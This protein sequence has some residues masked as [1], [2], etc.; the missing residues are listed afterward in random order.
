[1]ALNNFFKHILTDDEMASINEAVGLFGSD[2]K[3]ELEIGFKHID[4]TNYIRIIEEL[5]NINENKIES[6]VS[7]DVSILLA[8]GNSYRVS[9]QNQELIDSFLDKCI[10]TRTKLSISDIQRYLINMKLD[11]PG[12]EIMFKDKGS[13]TMIPISDLDIIFK[14]TKE[15][16]VKSDSSKP[17]LS[18]G[19]KILFRLKDRHSFVLNKFTRIDATEVQQSNNPWDLLS[20]RPHY[21]LE[22]EIINRKITL[23]E[24]FNETASML[25]I[26]QETSLPIGKKEAQ[27]VIAEYRKLLNSKNIHLEKRS[28]VSIEAHHIVRFIPNKYAITDKADGDRRFLFSVPDGVYLLS[29]NLTVTKINVTITKAKYQFMLLDGELVQNEHGKM[30]LLFDVVYANQIDYRHGSKFNLVNRI[31]VL[32]DIVS[33]CFGSLI[34]FKNFADTHTELDLNSISKFYAEELSTYWKEFRSQLKISAKKSELFITRK[35][36]FIPYGIES[37]EIFTYADLVWRL[38][39]YK[40]LVPYKLDGIIYTP[41]N[42]PYMIRASREEIDTVPLEYKWKNPEQNSIDFWIKFETDKNGSDI[43]FYDGST[44]N[45]TGRPYKIA[46]L[47]VGIS[48]GS[49][50]KPI[51]FK[52]GGVDQKAYIY[53]PG[54][55]ARDIEER[56]IDDRTVVEFIFDHKFVLDSSKTDNLI[57]QIDDAYKWIPI[58]TRYDKTE[59]VNKYNRMYGNP[60]YI[61]Q[62]IYR[63]IINPITESTISLLAKPVSFQKEFD[64]LSKEIKDDNQIPLMP[65][66]KQTFTYYEKETDH[67]KGMRAYHNWIKSN[68]ILTYCKNKSAVLDIGCGRGG[69]ISKFIGAGVGELV[70]IDRDNN[71]LYVINDCAYSRYKSA[72]KHNPKI[73]PMVFINAD[74]TGLFNVG[75]QEQILTNMSNQNK[76]LITTYLSKG[77]KYDVINCQFSLHYYLSDAISWK[78]FCQNINDHTTNNAYLLITTFDGS[79]VRSK[80]Q[81][82]SKLTISYTDNA[83]TKSTFA[84]ITKLYSDSD[85]NKLGLAIGVHNS[86]IS[87]SQTPPITEYIVEP[88]FLIKSMEKNCGMELVE[89]DSFFNLFELYKKYFGQK[90]PTS[91][92]GTGKKQY[93]IISM[94]YKTLDPYLKNSFTEAEI[95]IA[96]ASF[97]FSSLNRYYVFKKKISVDFDDP[98]RLVGINTK[99][100]LSKILTPYFES[101]QIMIDTV[102]SA[103]RINKLYQNLKLEYKGTKPSVYLIRHTILEDDLGNKE[104]FRRNL[105]ELTKIKEG[106]AQI[107]LIYKSPDRIFYPIYQRTSSQ[108]KYLFHDTKIISDLDI[109]VALTDKMNSNSNS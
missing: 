10:N 27:N 25:K 32:N 63:S 104:I 100:N 42:A 52:V 98:A 46:G 71:G 16:A 109:L 86:T 60:E 59:S 88:D 65:P 83:G 53:S 6:T 54:G 29:N 99:I 79:I 102:N 78:N 2:P 7:L 9:F 94:Y 56:A 14:L 72:Q 18:G 4:L 76:Q 49:Q 68:M 91:Y 47:F 105:I 19:E 103:P 48:E 13:A 20:R 64:R 21:E 15:M 55:T 51:A 1:M 81:K 40:N 43:I 8:G 24:L 66:P 95:Q 37:C 5:L 36:Y 11:I 62:R 58:K 97:A 33:V 31:S 70:G 82:K 69:D 34:P 93:E 30:L 57:E 61:A 101:N 50:E 92:T 26:I 39:V 28:T 41:L 108:D 77:K 87:N 89:S 22:L 23:K 67:G 12:T 90:I 73:P 75:S 106:S 96:K 45:G 74:A 107:S 44:K 80:L 35:L 17:V 38:S 85:T 3:L 84:E